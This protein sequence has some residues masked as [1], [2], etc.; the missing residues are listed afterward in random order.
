MTYSIVDFDG[1]LLQKQTVPHLLK[2]WK[3]RG[4]HLNAYRRVYR[5]MIR[6]YIRY[7]LK[8]FGL[9]Q[10]TFRLT[11]MQRLTQLFVLLTNEQLHA[12][13][14]D[15]YERAQPFI[16]QDVVRAIK[17]DKQKGMT[18]ILLSGNY[19]VFLNCF[20]PLGFD[21]VL[22]TRLY[23]DHEQLIK[24]PSIIIGD[25]KVDLLH[26]NVPSIHWKTTK[27]Y[28]DAYYDLPILSK[29][30]HPIVVTPDKKLMRYAKEKGWAFINQS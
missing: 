14:Q 15:A 16:N 23:D 10:K 26:K 5:W 22:G 6:R 29:V 27:G 11:A 17:D 1:T 30:G 24:N 7:K 12:F 21:I 19:D 18:I 28:A 20:K 3:A 25:K 8:I 9:D 2:T 13:F 4:L